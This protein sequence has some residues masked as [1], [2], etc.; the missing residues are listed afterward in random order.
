MSDIFAEIQK[1]DTSL[2][3]LLTDG[4]QQSLIISADTVHSSKRSSIPGNNQNEKE[5]NIHSG[6]KKCK[7]G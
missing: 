5:K 7:K 1:R 6:K 2:L 3:R 4:I